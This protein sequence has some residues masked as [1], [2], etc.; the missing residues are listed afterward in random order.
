MGE[1][2]HSPPCNIMV[3]KG[4][5]NV[6][7]SRKFATF[8]LEHRVALEYF[9]WLKNTEC[10]DEHYYSTLASLEIESEVEQTESQPH[11]LFLKQNLA[12]GK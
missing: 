12:D 3:M 4:Y 10:P 6:A 2:P 9:N 5:K 11:T 7:L 8:V 1:N